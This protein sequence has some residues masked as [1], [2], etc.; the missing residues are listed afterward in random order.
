MTSA[1]LAVAWS[2]AAECQPP[3]AVVVQDG[4]EVEIRLAD[5]PLG[6]F[7][8]VEGAEEYMLDD[9]TGAARLEDGSV[10]VALG[11]SSRVRRYDPSGTLQWGVGREGEG[12]GE[13]M[14]ARIPN[15]CV[16][17]ESVVVYDSRLARWT[18]LDVED[19]SL[20]DTWSLRDAPFDMICSVD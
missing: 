1:S 17:T 13:Y 4:P 6:V 12:P 7:G 15:G 19:G 20:I 18:V 9:I 16:G 14:H 11:R 2:A 5:A 3:P 10:V 8:V